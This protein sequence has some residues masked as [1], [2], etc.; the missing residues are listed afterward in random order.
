VD[1]D[2][3]REVTLLTIGYMGIVQQRDEAAGMT[4]WEL[5]QAAPGEPGQ[6]VVLAGEAVVDAWPGGVTRR[7]R[8]QVAQALAETMVAGQTVRPTLR[9]AAGDALGRLG[10]ARFR[11]DAWHLPDEP[12]LSF[13]Q[14]PAGPFLMGE[15]KEQHSVI[16]PAYYIARY[17]VTVA[18]FRAFVEDSGYQPGDPDSL[19]GLDNNPVV[20]VSWHDAQAYCAWLTK[21]LRDWEGTPEPLASLLRE[22]AEGS[23]PWQVRLPTEAEW[24]KASRGTDGRV[25]PWGDEPDSNRA[26]YRDTGIGRTSAVGCFPGG[27]STYGVQDLSG[28]VWEWCQS[29]YKPYPYNPEDARE[30]PGAEGTRV[31]RGGAFSYSGGYVR[32]AFRYWFIPVIG[33]DGIGFR[34]VVAPGFL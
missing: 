28:N 27:A 20:W 31:L 15:G 11:T 34:L 30:A 32:C 7:C 24:E 26:N 21:Q 12:L 1:D 18:Q 4:L 10:D 19:R 33:G 16:L 29:L 8:E 9:A 22:G 23:R 14:V 2:N 5:I 6:A 13:V 3:W 17:P 25:F